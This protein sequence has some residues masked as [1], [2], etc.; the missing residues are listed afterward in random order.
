MR[1][2]ARPSRAPGRLATYGPWMGVSGAAAVAAVALDVAG[3]DGLERF[4][5]PLPPVVAVAGAGAAGLGALVF[6]EQRGFWRHDTS[7]PPL[8]AVAVAA[9]AVVPLSAVAIGVDVLRGFPRDTNLPWPEAWA[10]YLSIAVVAESTLHLL[11]LAALV[12][13]TSARFADDRLDRRTWGL[14]LATATVEPVAQVAL[15]SAQQAFVVPHVFVFGVVQLLLLRRFGYTS[16]LSLRISYYLVWHV[17]WGR[18]R[19]ELLF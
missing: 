6:L 15:G 16:M 18:A 9:A 19:L 4:T 2:P 11:P 14:V 1:W 5:G 17:L 10:G 3:Y 8:R 13:A 7:F 12:W